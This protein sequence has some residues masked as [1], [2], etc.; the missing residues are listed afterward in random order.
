MA[1]R[2]AEYIMIQQHT[3]L[4]HKRLEPL[5]LPRLIMDVIL[6]HHENYDGSGYPN[7]LAGESIPLAARIIRI[8]D[9]YDALI[10]N[11]GYRSAL[12]RRRAL[13]IMVADAKNFDPGLW[14]FS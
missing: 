9:T 2:E 4:G 5:Q 8:T 10:S 14:I 7:G 12:S 3:A 13:D 1:N 11:R 6:S